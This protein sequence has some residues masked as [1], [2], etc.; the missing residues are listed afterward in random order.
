MANNIKQFRCTFANGLQAVMG[1]DSKEDALKAV[2]AME[3]MSGSKLIDVEE[4][5]AMPGQY[6][7]L[8]SG[9][10]M[11]GDGTEPDEDI[12]MGF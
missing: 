10:P 8:T 2:E 1:A 6:D 9:E 7:Y 3:R 12:D 5:E 11:L 4:I